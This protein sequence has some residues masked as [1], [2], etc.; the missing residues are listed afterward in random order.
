MSS[1][2]GPA[3]LEALER[4]R[5][6]ERPAREPVERLD[7]RSV[8]TDLAVANRGGGR[9][10]PGQVARC[11]S[12]PGARKLISAGRV[13]A[14]A[15][16]VGAALGDD[17]PGGDDR[18]PVGERLGLLHVVGG[19]EDRLAE[20]AQ[21]RRSPPTPG[22]APRD[23]SPWSA[24]RGRGGRG[25]RSARRRRRA[26]AAGPP[27]RLPARASAFSPSPT[28]SIVVVDRPW[29]AVVAG[30]ELERLAHG[31]L[32]PHPAL[33][34]DDPDPLP[35]LAPG[36]CRVDAEHRDLAG[37]AA[38]GSPRGSRSWSSCRRR[39]GRGRRTPRR[40]R[41]RGRVP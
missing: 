4:D 10:P 15:E 18:H 33:L 5:A 40:S 38:R 16:L 34:E 11:R 37:A 13:L 35:P 30:V 22:G 39:S 29:L 14:V 2:L 25:R 27:E 26:G 20:L 17:P 1:R 32:G 23:R 41:P 6:L 36:A 3:D 31:E 28:C 9:E 19:E 21:A 12:R 7:R 24:R 8:E